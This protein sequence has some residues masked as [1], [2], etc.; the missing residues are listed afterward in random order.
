MRTTTVPAEMTSVEDRIVGSLTLRQLV[1]LMAPLFIGAIIFCVLP[2][3]IKIDPYKLVVWLSISIP[4]VVL[5]VRIKGSLVLD[6]FILLYAYGS[7]AK[8]YVADKNSSIARSPVF[9]TKAKTTPLTVPLAQ[10]PKPS[11]PTI[12][13][14]Y[15]TALEEILNDPRKQITFIHSRKGALHV[16][17]NQ[18]R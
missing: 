5:A 12:I 8:T 3:K 15:T 18:T 17:I 11:P 10:T 6:W 9:R 1:L 16:R 2:P 7:R 4:L 14:T 13:P